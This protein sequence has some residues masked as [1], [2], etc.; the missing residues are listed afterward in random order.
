MNLGK[1]YELI[2]KECTQR[3]SQQSEDDAQKH[4]DL[5]FWFAAPPKMPELPMS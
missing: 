1:R 5:T 3:L 2:A 4:C